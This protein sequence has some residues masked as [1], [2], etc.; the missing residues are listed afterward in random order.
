VLLIRIVGVALV[1]TGRAM[2]VQLL[3]VRLF[4]LDGAN[5]VL[6]SHRLLNSILE[7]MQRGALH[8]ARFV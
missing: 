7:V 3:L 8:E 2:S 1:C 4:R 5:A 6:D